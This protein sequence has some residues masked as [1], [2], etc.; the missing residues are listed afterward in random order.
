M[1]EMLGELGLGADA[2]EDTTLVKGGLGA[3]KVAILAYHPRLGEEAET[4]LIRFV[5]NGGKVFVCY[6]L[7]HRLG[8]AIGFVGPK[9]ARQERDGQFAEIRFDAAD[10]PGLPRSVRQNSWNITDAKP[11]GH[12]ARVIARWHDEARKPTGHAAMLLSDRGAFF[13]HIFLADD[14]EGKRRMLA[15]I[16]GRLHPPLWKQMAEAAIGRVGAVGPYANLQQM[17]DDASLNGIWGAQGRPVAASR[18]EPLEKVR[19]R[20]LLEDYNG[21]VSQA[22]SARRQLVERYLDLA[23]SIKH[24]GRAMWNHSGA[25]AFPGDW[26]RTAKTLAEAASTW[27]CPTC[28]GAAWP[29]T[30]ATSSRGAIRSRST[31]TRSPSAWPRARSTAS[32]STSGR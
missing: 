30:P 9:Y 21:A 20:Y 11:S 6:S 22:E 25:G 18:Y 3:R 31:A 10:M 16:L 19:V 13:S 8:K 4:A 2:I 17:F 26:E 7:P 28:F 12:G 23:L 29:I 15:G 32:R 24:E 14:R 5:E 1:A 27:S